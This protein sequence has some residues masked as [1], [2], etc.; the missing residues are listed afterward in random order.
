MTFN[1]K[2]KNYVEY[3]LPVLLS[4]MTAFLKDF[5]LEQFWICDNKKWKMSILYKM[6]GACDT[7]KNY[8]LMVAMVHLAVMK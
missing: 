3:Y 7:P 2:K 6:L 4:K 8:S 5:N 1:W